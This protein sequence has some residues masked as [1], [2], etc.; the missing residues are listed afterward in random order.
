[1]NSLNKVML[2]G[3][4]GKI[5]SKTVGADILICEMSLATS[6][7]KK[8]Q[9]GTWDNITEWHNVTF[10]GK[11]AEAVMKQFS[12]GFKIYVEGEIKTDTWEKDGVKHYKTKIIGNTFVAMGDKNGTQSD[13]TSPQSAY[14]GSNYQQ[15]QSTP[16]D[17]VPF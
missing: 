7:G 5:E 9:D 13:N 8:N 2:I 12:K 11:T 3:N 17:D 6:K 14:T 4:I 16:E 10:F 15:P 1:M